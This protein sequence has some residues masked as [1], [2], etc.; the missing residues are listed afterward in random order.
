[1]K[2]IKIPIFFIF[3]VFILN[4]IFFNF[5]FATPQFIEIIEKKANIRIGPSNSET[6]IVQAKKGDI[7]EV[8]GETEKWYKINMFSGEYRY[9]NKSMVIPTTYTILLPLLL[10]ARMFFT[11]WKKPKI[12][13]W[14]KQI[15]NTRRIFIKIL[16]MKDF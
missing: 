2:D 10:F 8:K 16:I 3:L 12:A 5:A 6:I 7:F 15:K 9:V 11:F 1:M 14:M 4:I 13:L